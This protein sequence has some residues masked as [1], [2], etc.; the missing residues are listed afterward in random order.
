MRDLNS[1]RNRE[2]IPERAAKFQKIGLNAIAATATKLVNIAKQPT[3]CLILGG[4]A[5]DRTTF[6][7][8]M[9]EET[10]QERLQ[11]QGMGLQL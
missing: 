4:S 9:V 11:N 10:S 8:N 3:S 5:F 2:E 1:E 6:S 7:V